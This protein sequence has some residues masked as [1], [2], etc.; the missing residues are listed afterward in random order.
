MSG[1]TS[2]QGRPGSGMFAE[3]AGGMGICRVTEA[4]RIFV[5]T[6]GPELVVVRLLLSSSSSL[7]QSHLFSLFLL[8]LQP[9]V[10]SRRA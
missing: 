1:G 10:S 5:E 8:S 6:K 3:S 2:D 9:F 7:S 4:G